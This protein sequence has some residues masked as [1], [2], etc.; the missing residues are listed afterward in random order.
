MVSREVFTPSMILISL[1]RSYRYKT[2]MALGS[3]LDDELR[4]MDDLAIQFLKTYQVWHHRR[5]ILGHVRKPAPELAFI[6]SSLEVD[7]KNYHTWSYRQWLLA[8]FNDEDLWAG[9]LGFVERMLEE[10]VRNN[11]AWHHRFFIVF[12]SGVR[13]GE[14][15]RDTVAKRELE[16]AS[17]RFCVCPDRAD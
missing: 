15:D 1:G 7:A 2:L 11:S 13:K 16:C 3:P 10:D 8:H 14:E 17:A 9:E 5:L 6:A 4:L 12:Q